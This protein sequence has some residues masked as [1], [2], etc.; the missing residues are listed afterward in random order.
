MQAI[1][2]SLTLSLLKVLEQT[3]FRHL[4]QEVE[5]VSDKMERD[6]QE[7][8]NQMMLL[9][10]RRDSSRLLL[11]QQVAKDVE[12]MN[13]KLQEMENRLIKYAIG[14]AASFSAA[15]LAL[16]RIVQAV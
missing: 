6:Y 14:F 13:Y 1:F 10:Q 4:R 15:G 16:A 2:D 12:T 7:I 5:V 11:E 8:N 3:D 9:E